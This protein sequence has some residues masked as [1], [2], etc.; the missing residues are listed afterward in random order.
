VTPGF[1][2]GDCLDLLAQMPPKSVHCCVTSPPYYALRSYLPEGHPDK[3][4]EIGSEPTLDAFLQTMVTV[5]R[6]VW[7]VLRDDGTLWLNI[8][9]S[10]AGAGGHG[11]EP[12]YGCTS[13]GPNGATERA[14]VRD[15]PPKNL[16][17]VPARVALA[18]QADGWILRSDIIWAKCLSGGTRLY[19]RTQKGEGPHT[20][21]DLV[22][23]D[24]STVQLWNGERWTQVVSWTETPRPAAPM[25]LKLRSGETIGCTGDH[26]WPTQR[27]LLRA[28]ELKTGDVLQRTDLPDPEIPELPG[29]LPDGLGWFVGLFIAEGS[30]GKDGKVIQIAG[31]EDEHE[32]HEKL[33]RIAALCGGTCQVHRTSEHGVTCN[34]YS[35]VLRAILEMYVSGHNAKG[36]HLHQRCWQRS[37]AFLQFVIEGYLDGDGH[38]TG[39]DHWKLGFA[40]N[41]ELAA[42]LRTLAARLGWSLRLKRCKHRFD[43]RDF[44]GWRG[45]VCVSR[46]Q[47][48]NTKSDTEI[49]RI[50]RSRAR[51]FWDVEVED[52]P[53]LFALASGVLTHNSNPMPESCRDRPTNAH[54]H[55][56]LFAKR[57]RYYFDQE[58]VREGVT[59]NAHAHGSGVGVKGA[60]FGQG[61]KNNDSF[62]PSI[63][64]ATTDDLPTSRNLRNVW[65]IPTQAV[66]FKHYATFPEK[67]VE[68]CIKAGTSQEGVCVECGAPWERVVEVESMCTQE[69]RMRAQRSEDSIH[70]L[71]KHFADDRGHTGKHMPP[72][73][74]TETG[75]RPTCGC[76]AGTKPALVLDPFMGSG[77]VA[78]VCE[79]LGREWLGFDLDERNR[80][81]C[82]KRL[83]RVQKEL[84]L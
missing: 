77:T 1:Y 42:D 26:R 4:K 62:A 14:T 46:R 68:P 45:D 10:Y 59:G 82:E 44:P 71:S 63:R 37:H 30:Y 6:A 31:H 32:R 54:E 47:H 61:V 5:F 74:R 2:V 39:C 49:V 36:K 13:W 51:K 22:R 84:L 35:P 9:D 43:G 29:F 76:D 15:L 17:M 11:A 21:K 19:A 66:K 80:E 8:G 67:L 38:Y 3:D 55:V 53:H 25:E 27:G 52:D 72:A 79:R 83:R 75:W 24:P 57:P 40:K 81:M 50:G 64:N 65:T 69:D 18:L 33:R 20:L 34:I 41:D 28:D 12:Q 78:R 48:S 16:L 23:L 70:E 7:R 60:P 73:K 58:A 56:F